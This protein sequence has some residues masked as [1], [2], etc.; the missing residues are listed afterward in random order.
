MRRREF[1]TLLGGATAWSLAARA[2]QPAVPV[3]VIGL[4]HA[5]APEESASRIASFRQGLSKTGYEEGRNLAIDYRWADGQYDRLPAL[6]A[7][8]VR[9]PVSVLVGTT[10]PAALA[11]KAATTT[12]PIVFTTGGDPVAL[13]LVASLNRPGSNVTGATL[14]ARVLTAKQLGLL[15]ELVPQVAIMGF[16]VNPSDAN[17]E[18]SISDIHAA[19]DALGLRLIVLKA[20]TDDQIDA[21]FAALIQ[22]RVGALVVDGDPF[23]LSRRDKVLAHAQRGSIP[24][25]YAFREYV[26]A[27]GLMSYAPNLSDAYRQAGIY[28][29]RILKGEKPADLPVVQATKFDL[30]INLKTAKL[31]GLKVPLTL[32]GAADEVIE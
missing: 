28:A 2:Q 5:G 25:I 14:L 19:A 30:A 29:G 3:P 12:I 13:G 7:E 26:V 22:Q 32:E 15:H 18:A 1:I 8:L 4:L 17:A 11:A 16:L 6:A 23:I 24:A 20:G 31:L 10:T 9:R 21:A 27:G